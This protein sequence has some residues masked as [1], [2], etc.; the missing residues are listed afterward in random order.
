MDRRRDLRR[1]RKDCL[2]R[3]RALLVAGALGASGLLASTAPAASAYCDPKYEP[4]CTN[5][6]WMQLPPT[7]PNKLGDW[8]SRV[9]PE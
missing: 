1:S 3:L 4:L 2:M 7:D 9:C 6:C 8:L 5:G